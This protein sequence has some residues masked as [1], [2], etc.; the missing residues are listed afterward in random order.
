MDSSVSPDRKLRG[1][2]STADVALKRTHLRHLVRHPATV[3]L[4][5]HHRRWL[6]ASVVLLAGSGVLWLVMHY[7]AHAPGE[8]GE[9][10]HPLEALAVKLHGAA[11][12]W[13][14][15]MLG[16]M[17]P[18][19]VVKAWALRKNL[20]TGLAL[21]AVNATLIA[22]GYCLYYVSSER[23]HPWISAVH[24]GVG[25]VLPLL[26]LVHLLTRRS[27]VASP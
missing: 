6:Y 12:M 19:H 3:T 27:R 2:L 22:T 10:R 8:F 16:T 4:N 25:V 17:L 13:F 9:G 18:A 15:V 11:A 7:F 14:L 23:A 20:A 21:L 24:W 26:L 1:R 5:R